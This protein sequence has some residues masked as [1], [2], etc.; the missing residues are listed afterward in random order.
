M[1]PLMEREQHVTP[2]HGKRG[3]QVHVSRLLQG[4]WSQH[5]DMPYPARSAGACAC[6][7]VELIDVVAIVLAVVIA[8]ICARYFDE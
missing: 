8:V 1:R 3:R 7:V 2:W 5:N 6:R 4:M